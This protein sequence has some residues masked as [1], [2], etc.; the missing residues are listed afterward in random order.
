MTAQNNN[1]SIAPDKE[2][3]YQNKVIEKFKSIGYRYMGSFQYDRGKKCNSD[4]SVNSPFLQ[5][6]MKD[7]LNSRKCYTQSQIDDVYRE[8][9]EKAILRDKKYE[10]LANLN[11][12]VYENAIIAGI[13][14]KP[15]PDKNEQ[16]VMLIDFDNY[17]SNDFAI[18]EEVSYI[19]SLTGAQSR[20]DLV[21]Y[22]NG[23]AVAVIE[24]KRSTVSIVEGIKQNLSN[25][26][27]LIPSF[28]T[29]VQFVAVSNQTEGF[30]YATIG[31]GEKFWCP[32]KPD[33][34][35]PNEKYSDMQAI[36]EFFNKE[37]FIFMLRY[38][39]LFDGGVKKV[40]RPHQYYAIRAS[41][42][43]LKNKASGVIWH[44]QGSG[45]SL[46]MVM[47]A[48]Y[49]KNNFPN[50]RV[51][52]ITDRTELDKQLSDDFF[53]SG[54]SI[55]RVASQDDLLKTL[56]GGTEWLIFTLI[57]KFGSHEM[58]S[59]QEHKIPLDKYLKELKDIINSSYPN[60]KTKGS[61][62]FVFIDECHRTQGGRLHEAMRFIM[63]DDVMLIGFTGTPLLK[64]DKKEGYKALQKTSQVKFGE[65]IHRYLHKQAI[66][67][68]VILDL[69]YEARDV[70]QSINS[71]KKLDQ[72]LEDIVKDLSDD[73]KEI[74]K[75]RWSTLEK[76]FSSKQRI[77]RIAWS[78]LDDMES[79]SLLTQSWCNAMLIADSVYAAY[80]YYDFFQNICTNTTLRGRVAV[81]TSYTPSTDDIRKQATDV[82]K[83]N[84]SQF[85]YRLVHQSWEDASSADNPIKTSEKYE[86]WAKDIFIK[87]PNNL[88]LL[89]V[90]DKLLT[91]FDAPNATFLYIDR[92]IQD[93]TL[94][95]AICR[96]NRLGTNLLD[97]KNNVIRT[98]KEFGVIV[99]F[100]HLFG[101]IKDTI[102]KFNDEDG[103]LG[104][105]EPG[106]IEGLLNDFVADNKKRLMKSAEAYQALKKFWE[107]KELVTIELIGNFYVTDFP[108]D[109]ANARRTVLYSIAGKLVSSFNNL[110]DYM[111]KA[112]FSDKDVEYYEKLVK[113]AALVMEYVKQR[114]GDVFDAKQFDPDMRALLDRYIDAKEAEVIV[115]PTADFSF[116][117]LIDSPDDNADELIEKAK[118]IAKGNEKT[119]TE[120]IVAKARTVI[121]DAK[122]SDPA[123]Y[124]LFSERLQA[125][126]D[127][128]NENTS[129]F[130]SSMR[131]LIDL[132]KKSKHSSDAPKEISHN[133]RCRALW[134]NR[135]T[136][137]ADSDDAVAIEQIKTIDEIVEYEAGAEYTDPTSIDAKR[138]KKKI[139]KNLPHLSD[140]Q[141][142]DIYDICVRNHGN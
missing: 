3:I 40:A 87:Q 29:T 119:A 61:N 6:E 78:I 132:V 15:S 138:L 35:N 121:N 10:S 14:A 70:E 43:R 68:K 48:R 129:S 114:S 99:D 103:A 135:A 36:E 108:D 86:A 90:V 131:D 89:I 109:P 7:F 116:L 26:K 71:K 63:G 122:E 113:E 42:Q 22:I 85:K 117:D 52:V 123:A 88:K 120:L 102:T 136:W 66:A 8:F 38:C 59:D 139:S 54:N 75:K 98:K 105:Y 140:M 93:H 94:F 115:E 30:K 124:K 12:D 55:K 110:A 53:D 112:G 130:I 65:F 76:V 106:D 95:Q 1:N 28:F 2:R 19:D 92:F 134:N 33:T 4:G 101:K 25:T 64:N 60:F 142:A 16:D 23:I 31:T 83:E 77:E 49:I 118:K 125:I 32:F 21:I 81:V 24:L 9:R 128:I 100:M 11:N 141:V 34:N 37:H 39:V 57:H 96:V 44:S 111:K 67:D 20:P 79:N 69:Q 133:A 104:G 47:L 45:K 13:K 74:V 18:A 137:G 73:R 58:E 127:S 62:I 27:D 97:D 82:N 126:I 46:T 51:V 50:P 56:N 80:K 17:E 41:E 72:K 84:Q 107:G 91:G 5:K